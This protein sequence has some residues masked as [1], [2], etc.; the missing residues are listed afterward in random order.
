MLDEA[1]S[2]YSS[3]SYKAKSPASRFFGFLPKNPLD[4]DEIYIDLNHNIHIQINNIINFNVTINI[5]DI[6]INT[7]IGI[8]INID[9]NINP[10]ININIINNSLF[11]Y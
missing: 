1:A 5:I 10:D 2:L 11:I 4:I 9:F 3:L 7:N 6:D 8:E